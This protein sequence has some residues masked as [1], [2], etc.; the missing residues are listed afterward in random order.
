MVALLHAL[1]GN[2]M[3]VEA[4]GGGGCSP[5]DGQVTEKDTGLG[6]RYHLQRQAQVTN[7]LQQSLQNLPR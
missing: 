3:V 1:P 7:F 4:P 2:T 6:A 5:H